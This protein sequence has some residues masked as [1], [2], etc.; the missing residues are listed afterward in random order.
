MDIC[1]LTVAVPIFNMEWCLRKN[2][3]TYDDPRL[4]GKLEVLCLNNASEDASGS[5]A[6]EFAERNPEVFR[7]FDRDDRGYGASIN[8]AIAAAS[9]R[10]F[11]IVDA[12]DWVD[13]EE[14]VRLA[15]ALSEC[16]ADIV[17]TDYETVD[18]Q[19]GKMTPVKAARPG[20]E[21]G[22]RYETFEWPEQT[23]PSIHGTAYRT[24]LLRASRFQMQDKCFFVDEEYVTLPYLR[25]GSVIYLPFD[26][27]RYQ[28][29]NPEQ[30]TSPGNRARLWEHRERVLRRLIREYGAEKSEAPGNKALAYCERRVAKG[31]GDHFTTLLI[32]VPD[33]AKGRALAR[34]W[35]AYV[36]RA[37]PELWGTVRRKAKLLYL[38]NRMRVSLPA[39]LRMKRVLLKK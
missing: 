27:Y 7:L 38:L 28:V 1:V 4:A 14:L 17:L 23:L 3:A 31:I 15:E 12:D 8:E 20:L 21:Y 19:T 37:V 35:E 9:G 34:E 30:S 22:K 36:R 26:V 33:R 11:R 24:E 25:A 29:A 2:L 39:Y 10:Y 16:D 32:Y 13:T 18:L 6:D 5:I